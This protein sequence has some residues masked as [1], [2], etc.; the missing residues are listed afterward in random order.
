MFLGIKTCIR[1]PLVRDYVLGCFRIK[2][3]KLGDDLVWILLHFCCRSDGHHCSDAN[4]H[5]SS[6]LYNSSLCASAT[7][8]ANKMV[9]CVSI[10]GHCSSRCSFYYHILTCF[11]PLFMMKSIGIAPRPI[12]LSIPQASSRETVN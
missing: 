2:G 3:E 11:C 8:V 1:S 9:C 6:H 5:Y 12:G 10:F 7:A 4:G